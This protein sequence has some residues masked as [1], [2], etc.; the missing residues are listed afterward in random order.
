MGKYSDGRATK[1]KPKQGTNQRDRERQ[2]YYSIPLISPPLEQLVAGRFMRNPPIDDDDDKFHRYKNEDEEEE[3]EEKDYNHQTDRLVPTTDDHAN[4]QS[5]QHQH[6]QQHSQ[7]GLDSGLTGP[8]LHSKKQKKNI[9]TTPQTAEQEPPPSSPP[10][11]IPPSVVVHDAICRS[12]HHPRGHSEPETKTCSNKNN[13]AAAAAAAGSPVAT[14]Q[15]SVRP[16]SGTNRTTAA[17]ISPSPNTTSTVRPRAVYYSLRTGRQGERRH[18]ISPTLFR[19][20]SSASSSS[21]SQWLEGAGTAPTDSGVGDK[22]SNDANPEGGPVH[23]HPQTTEHDGS[24]P[25]APTNPTPPIT[26]TTTTAGEFAFQEDL[27]DEEL[28]VS[29]TLVVDQE[30]EHPSESV[31]R[32]RRRRP[33]QPVVPDD[34]HLLLLVEARTLESSSSLPATGTNTVVGRPDPEAPASGEEP[35][36]PS[37]TCTGPNRGH[38]VGPWDSRACGGGGGGDCGG[39]DTLCHTYEWKGQFRRVVVSRTLTENHRLGS[40]PHRL[41]ESRGFKHH[42]HHLH[43]HYIPSFALAQPIFRSHIPKSENRL[44]N[45]LSRINFGLDIPSTDDHPLNIRA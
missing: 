9:V 24:W 41:V 31:S 27:N 34:S 44:T 37:F 35:P 22:R 29:A 33:P 15:D 40:A 36:H 28:L 25:D 14:H 42:L 2:Y 18:P 43:P 10:I 17:S 3:E 19:T 4:S 23:S 12:F 39:G 32:R 26:S 13:T 45:V 8:S 11:R 7:G 21:V 30:V 20:R 16:S 1:A 6:P 5:Q 38:G